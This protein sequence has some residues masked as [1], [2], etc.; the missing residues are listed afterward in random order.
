MLISRRHIE[1]VGITVVPYAIAFSY[2]TLFDGCHLFR[3]F[4]FEQRNLLLAEFECL[5]DFLVNEDNKIQWQ[6]EKYNGNVNI[7]R[8]VT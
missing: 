2:E 5:F 6:H 8:T 4:R 3:A 7:R 1:V